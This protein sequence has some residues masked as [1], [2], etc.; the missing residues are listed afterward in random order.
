MPDIYSDTHMDTTDNRALLSPECV[1]AQYSEQ[2]LPQYKGNPLIEALPL[3]ATD[4]QVY[5]L[6]CLEPEFSPE[7]RQWS[8]RERVQML[9][10]LQNFLVPLGAHVE[11]VCT[12]DAL[13]R[14]GYVA[15]APRTPEQAKRF[16]AI[17]EKQKR[18]ETFRQTATTR[19]PQLSTLLIGISGMGKTT[20]VERWSAHIPKVIY[21]PELHI[22][23]VP[24]LHV[25]MPSDGSSIKGLAHGILEQLDRLIPGANY[26]ETFALKGRP[27]ADALMRSVA[28]LMNMHFVGLLIADEVQNLLNAKK[29]GQ[30]VMT[31]LVSACN[32]LGV[33]ILFIGTNK[34]S[35]VFSLDFRQSRRASGHGLR[36]WDR[37]PAQVEEG[38]VDEWCEFTSVLWKYQ[39]VKK[40]VELNAHLRDTLYFYSQ[41]VI[42]I[43]IKLFAAAQ[44]RA[45]LDGSETLS[46]EL[47]ASVYEKELKL[48]HPMVE[49]LRDNDLERLAKFDDISPLG[50]GDILES[51]ERRL[52]TKTSRVFSVKPQH[53]TFVP[54][55]AASLV[56][57]GFGEEES[58]QTALTVAQSDARNMVQASRAAL[59]LLSVPKRVTKSK[60]K[61]SAGIEDEQALHGDDP[62]DYRRAVLAAKAQGTTV[63]TQ[64][65]KMGA[66]KPLDELL[67]LA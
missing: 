40:P 1:I 12:L 58:E 64:L 47:F 54:R 42:D 62:S 28:R 41:G 14:A 27:G 49:A 26:Y 43:A 24:Y 29:G 31:E 2:R 5:E 34:A 19:N 4:E 44:G 65:Q 46:A 18:G 61:T 56:A 45:I 20:T 53:P 17:Y 50:L 37:L 9:M 22:Y 25:E 67:S 36:P 32:D 11:L 57:A 8:A 7:Q 59:D 35:K 48:L 38:E 30:A 13:L 51:I 33:P 63:Y 15:R 60:T 23:Q 52:K 16:Q 6:L 21:H 3:S 55:L 66:A 39:W 10:T